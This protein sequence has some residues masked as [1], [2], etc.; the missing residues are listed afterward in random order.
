MRLDCSA[1]ACSLLLSQVA[2]LQCSQCDVIRHIESHPE[3]DTTIFHCHVV[4]VSLLHIEDADIDCI[5][6][7]AQSKMQ[8]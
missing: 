6:R 7:A 2:L 3:P 1:P 4:A 8:E 5:L